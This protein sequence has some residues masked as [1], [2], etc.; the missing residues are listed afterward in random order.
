MKLSK[1]KK[2]IKKII[3]LKNKL[4]S[5]CL[6]LTNMQYILRHLTCIFHLFKRIFYEY[7][8]N[9]LLNVFPHLLVTIL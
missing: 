2:Y 8:E 1:F 5:L 9:Q 6:K 7:I 3:I 4:T